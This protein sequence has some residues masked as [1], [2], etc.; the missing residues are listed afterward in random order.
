MKERICL[1]IHSSKH[2]DVD[3]KRCG[4]CSVFDTDSSK[5]IASVGCRG[6]GNSHK[7][8]IDSSLEMGK[9]ARV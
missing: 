2:S 1:R 4:R 6:S 5:I 8:V 3:L 9:C 7:L